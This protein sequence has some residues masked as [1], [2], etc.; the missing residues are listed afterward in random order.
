MLQVLA[1]HHTMQA[2]LQSLGHILPLSP[3]SV[4]ALTAAV[5]MQE[6]VLL[7]TIVCLPPGVV[8]IHTHALKYV[9]PFE[10]EE[11]PYNQPSCE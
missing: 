9:F 1:V 11:L 6:T 5:C 4:T 7:F 10:S 3:R 2:C 8:C